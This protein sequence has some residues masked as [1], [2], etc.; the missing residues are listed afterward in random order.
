MFVCFDNA[1]EDVVNTDMIVNFWKEYK[2]YDD[3]VIDYTICMR[4]KNKKKETIYFDSEEERDYAFQKLM[5]VLD[6]TKL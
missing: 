1:A 4:F 2:R 5:D 3:G 6:V